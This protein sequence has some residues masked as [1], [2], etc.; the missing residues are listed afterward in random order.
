[1]STARLGPLRSRW[2]ETR[3]APAGA[4]AGGDP[5][6][7]PEG[8]E[9]PLVGHHADEHAG[10]GAGQVLGCHRGV[11]DRPPRALQQQPLLRGHRRGLAWRDAEEG[12]IEGVGVVEEAAAHG[13]AAAGRPAVVGGVRSGRG[14]EVIA[15]GVPALLGHVARAVAS[16]HEQRPVLLGVAGAGKAAVETDDRDG[17]AHAH[18]GFPPSAARSASRSAR[19]AAIAWTVGKSYA[20]VGDTGIRYFSS[21]S[22]QM[23]I[24]ATESMP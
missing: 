15:L 16:V 8:Q 10:R 17:L 1:M 24:A 3:L 4:V 6:V 20:I 19:W 7:V 11:L 18:D 13:V 22:P 14:S 23:L 2:Y 9:R 21:I 5:V 12:G